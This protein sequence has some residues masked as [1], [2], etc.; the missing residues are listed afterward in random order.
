MRSPCFIVKG[1]PLSSSKEMRLKVSVY[2][3]N[4]DFDGSFVNTLVGLTAASYVFTQTALYCYLFKQ[5][6][7]QVSTSGTHSK[8]VIHLPVLLPGRPRS[9]H[10]QG[11]QSGYSCLLMYWVG[12]APAPI[13]CH[14]FKLAAD[15][16]PRGPFGPE[17]RG[18]PQP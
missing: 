16:L 1:D 11:M 15:A 6:Q 4:C 17:P 18:G 5:Q 12:R 10:K 2:P 7:R 14:M 9:T 13:H 3:S 8:S